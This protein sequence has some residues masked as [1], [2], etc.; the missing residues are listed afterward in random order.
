MVVTY[1]DLKILQALIENPLGSIKKLSGD[2]DLSPPTFKKRLE[3]LIERGV[4]QRKGYVSA[5]ICY[6]A[7]GLELVAVLSECNPQGLL[8]ME[9]VCDLHPYTRYRARCLGATNGIFMMFALPHGTLGNLI[10][11]MDALSREGAVVR[12]RIQ[13]PINK[14]IYSEPD[15]RLYDPNE[16]T[17]SFDWQKWS[18]TMEYSSPPRLERFPPSVMDRINK[19]DIRTLRIL[20]I[21]ARRSRKEIAED[22]ALQPYELSRRLNFFRENRVIDR[23]RIILGLR[24]FGHLTGALFEGRA[25]VEATERIAY[26]VSQLLFQSTF[27]PTQS[28]YI[29]YS[30]IQASDFPML[31]MELQRQSRSVD[32]MWCDYASTMR[33]WFDNEPSNFTVQGWRA[34][35]EYMI[36]DVL[37]KLGS[38]GPGC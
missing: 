37:Q 26:A 6:P 9:K 30:M 34:D 27:V 8:L 25:S 24:Q 16:N 31:A 19:A 18:N 21:D 3:R 10:Q 4:L 28:G 5:Q 1:A 38:G 12:Y 11:L 2:A 35:K 29:L 7:V 17:W 15:L 32:V 20:S 13:T 14:W 36:G 23:Y 22:V 33:Y